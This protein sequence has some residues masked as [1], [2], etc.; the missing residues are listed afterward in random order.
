MAACR[1]RALFPP[2]GIRVRRAI[3]CDNVLPPKCRRTRRRGPRLSRHVAAC[4]ASRTYA[5]ARKPTKHI[6]PGASTIFDP[7][8]SAPTTNSRC[9]SNMR[10]TTRN[11]WKLTACSEL[12]IS[13]ARM[14]KSSENHSARPKRSRPPANQAR[15]PPRGSAASKLLKRR[16]ASRPPNHRRARSKSAISGGRCFRDRLPDRRA[17]LA[18]VGK[19]AT[20]QTSIAAAQKGAARAFQHEMARPN[21]ANQKSGAIN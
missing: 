4:S 19:R 15:D 1:N 5:R 13:D 2:F 21:A 18:S 14:A 9:R 10:I 17:P 6:F 11:S 12:L 8:L 3:R 7:V 16:T 20:A